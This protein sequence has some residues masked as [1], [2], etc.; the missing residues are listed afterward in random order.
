MKKGKF[1]FAL[2]ILMSLLLLGGCQNKGYS[3]KQAEKIMAEFIQEKYGDTPEF[4]WTRWYRD[5]NRSQGYYALTTEGYYIR[6]NVFTSKGEDPSYRCYDTREYDL[7]ES[8]LEEAFAGN[9]LSDNFHVDI[10]PIYD[11]SQERLWNS[12]RDAY[13]QKWDGDLEKFISYS[14]EMVYT[15]FFLEDRPRTR[16]F[17]TI[18]PDSLNDYVSNYDSFREYIANNFSIYSD[19]LLN[20]SVLTPTVPT[21]ALD[22]LYYDEATFGFNPIYFLD[23]LSQ[24]KP[25]V[26]SSQVE[27]IEGYIIEDKY[28]ESIVDED[29]LVIVSDTS[30]TETMDS[31]TG[32]SYRIISPLYR[33]DKA[34]QEDIIM[35]FDLSIILKDY[36]LKNPDAKLGRDYVLLEIDEYGTVSEEAPP[37]DSRSF[38]SPEA[39]QNY[40]VGD[41]KYTWLYEY[42]Q[43]PAQLC[44]AVLESE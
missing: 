7:V 25:V 41:N 32:Q 13:H 26:I 5:R 31:F 1:M 21:D 8:A 12:L 19:I 4:E 28:N 36:L 6:M 3:K 11:D 30:S 23:D 38:V 34:Q 44:F 27:G 39:A 9:P 10:N 40:L 2:I 35:F 29:S 42:Y 17:I 43:D 20:V 14:S 22:A 16:T 24:R 18:R 33:V 37:F 15:A